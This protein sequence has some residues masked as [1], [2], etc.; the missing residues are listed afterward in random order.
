MKKYVIQELW[1]S[2]YSEDLE[3]E[4]KNKVQAIKKYLLHRKFENT[5]VVYDSLK[6]H[7]QDS[8]RVICVQEGYFANGI[9][10]IRGRRGFYK[11][12]TKS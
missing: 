6:N 9:K 11:I 2:L 7:I 8:S 12:L 10:F 5:K 3:F 1:G 4:A